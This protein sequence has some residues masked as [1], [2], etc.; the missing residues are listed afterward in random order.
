MFLRLRRCLDLQINL[1]RG[2]AELSYNRKA[3]QVE[4]R[5]FRLKESDQ[6]I[7]F[8]NDESTEDIHFKFMK[9]EVSRLKNHQRNYNKITSNI[10]SDNLRLLE[11]MGLGEYMKKYVVVIDFEDKLDYLLHRLSGCNMKSVREG[12]PDYL[13]FSRNFLQ[14]NLNNLGTTKVGV[15]Y[16]IDPKLDSYL[17]M[18][19]NKVSISIRTE[20]EESNMNYIVDSLL[21][22]LYISILNELIRVRDYTVESICVSNKY[23]LIMRSKGYSDFICTCSTPI[24][25]DLVLENRDLKSGNKNMQDCIIRA[26]NYRI[27]EYAYKEVRDIELSR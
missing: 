5:K 22:E 11:L 12:I 13:S 8:L 2:E 7:N 23:D 15:L 27:C 14:C 20:T 1:F 10:T 18:L 9:Q 3:K 6:Y 21:Y 16:D 26:K 19:Y 25:E 24:L 4:Y 17:D